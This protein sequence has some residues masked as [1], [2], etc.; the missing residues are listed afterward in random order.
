MMRAN[1]LNADVLFRSKQKQLYPSAIVRMW[2]SQSDGR[3]KH[4]ICQFAIAHALISESSDT[5][6]SVA[7]G[8]VSVSAFEP[9]HLWTDIT[10]IIIM[11]LCC[12][13]FILILLLR[14]LNQH[15]H[16]YCS[17][18]VVCVYLGLFA[19]IW[20]GFCASTTREMG[21]SSIWYNCAIIIIAAN[22]NTL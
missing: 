13:Q 12:W 9:L 6:C 16:C 2:F 20:N 10:L 4:I 21:P 7:D 3:P 5:S 8:R 19:N 22:Q 15:A 18:R 17:H 1:R 11:Q 14:V